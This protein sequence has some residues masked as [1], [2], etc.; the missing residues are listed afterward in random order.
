MKPQVILVAA[1]V[2][3]AAGLAAFLVLG[4]RFSAPHV[5]SGYIEGE[6]LYPATP[7]S[8]RLVELAVQRGDTVKAGD[9]LFTVDPTQGEATLDQA[10]AELATAQA[11]AADARRGQRPAELGVIEAD[12][13]A[14]RAQLKE[15]QQALDRI[16]P[17]VKAGALAPAQ[18]DTA[19]ATR[20]TAQ[21]N[22]NAVDKRLQAARLG[23]RQDQIAAADERV[24]Q[25]KASVTAARARLADQSQK[26]PADG[27]VEDVFFQTGE[28]TPA[29][30]PVLSLI[31]DTRVRLR[32]F[33]PQ[34]SIA[35]Y[36]IG[37]EIAFA[38]DACPTGQHA[39]ITYVAPRPEFT[40][41]VIYSREARDRMVFMVE[42]EPM[43]DVR[44]VPGQ[45]IDVTPL[46]TAP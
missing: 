4:P 39:R 16:S 11:L 30:Q 10:L 36:A 23:S 31:P 21:A 42:A 19:Q 26:A 45:P 32:F 7:L 15:A 40:P 8:G 17:L 24:H 6:A 22:V 25:A 29:N 27:R 35:N 13:A 44:L 46:E 43:G 12:L 14:A 33:A 2:A 28:W 34:T 20:D 41:P 1:L 37:R 3:G 9:L 38:C 5:L 18:L